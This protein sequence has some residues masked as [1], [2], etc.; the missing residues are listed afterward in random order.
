MPL[1]RKDWLM[2]YDVICEVQRN[3]FGVLFGLN[4]MYVH[5]PAFKWSSISNS[6]S[7]TLFSG[8]PI[9]VSAIRSYNFSGLIVIQEVLQQVHTY[10]PGVNVDEQ[11]K[12]I[13]YFVK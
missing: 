9:N 7:C 5:H 8:F 3:I 1:L 12:S 10:A 11:E 13:F 2:L 6:N 4:K